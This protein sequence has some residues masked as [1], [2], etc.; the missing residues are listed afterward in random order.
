V[1]FDIDGKCVTGSHQTLFK[2]R[3]RFE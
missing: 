1:V 2:K 3:R